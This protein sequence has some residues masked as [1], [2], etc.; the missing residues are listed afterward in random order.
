[1]R[2]MLVCAALS[3]LIALPVAAQTV[4]SGGDDGWTTPGG[5]ASQLNLGSFPIGR[6]LG[7]EP[8]STDVSLK[9]KPLDA[10]LGSIDTLLTRSD[11]T[12]SGG[13]GTGTLRIVALNLE[14]EGDVV[15]QD[16]RRYRLRVCLS[17]AGS[18]TGS[19]SLRKVNADG[20]TFSSTLPVLPKLIFSPTNGGSA[21]TIDCGTGAC[22]EMDMGSANT[23][24]VQAG[25]GSSFDPVAK[26]VTPIRSGV[27]VDSD[28]D[29]VKGGQGDYT[30]VGK[31]SGVTF[32]AGFAASPG[33]AA[34]AVG[35]RHEDLSWHQALPALDCAATAASSASKRTG[36]AVANPTPTPALCPVK[37]LP[38]DPVAN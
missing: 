10:G 24:W 15:L 12:L 7:S 36:A 9:G 25:G 14:S 17:K 18:S 13:S 30:T 16:G 33:H 26:G 4:I 11:I 5:G 3:C 34:V 31:G 23:G 19:A 6:F 21:V 8:V 35:E 38:H 32:H 22:P 1:M 20:G 27:V 37:T 2:R 28:C 29:G